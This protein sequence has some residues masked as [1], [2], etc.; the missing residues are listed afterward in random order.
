MANYEKLRKEI[1]DM[2][3]EY[4]REDKEV[5][6]YKELTALERKFNKLF[7][8]VSFQLLNDPNDKFYG[9]WLTN[10]NRVKCYV[11]QAPMSHQVTNTRINLLLNPLLLCDYDNETFKLFMKHE[12][13]HLISEHY[14]RVDELTLKYPR[15]LPLLSADLVANCILE[16]DL[17]NKLPDVFWTDR[18]LKRMF[19]IDINL[20][21]D[22]STVE[23]VCEKLAE[24][25]KTNEL[26][27]EFI[28]KGSG[29]DAES[30]LFKLN[31]ALEKLK[32]MSITGEGEGLEIVIPGSE[33]E[34][35]EGGSGEGE[36]SGDGNAKGGSSL[37]TM[38]N[39]LNQSM[40]K[41]KNADSLLISD[42]LKHITIDSIS[43]SRGKYPGSLAGLIKVLTAPPVITWES[44]LRR[45]IGSIA[46]GKKPTL[47][48]RNRRLP[49]RIDLKGELRDKEI[50]LVVAIDT[51][52]SMSDEVIGKCM[53]EIF[54]ITRLMKA[55]ITILEFDSKVEREYKANTKSDVKTEVLGRGGTSFTPVFEWINE[56]KKKESVLLVMSDGFGENKLGCKSN[57]HQ[58]TL[59]LMT[60]AREDLSLKGA[61][62]PMR[63]K[64]ISLTNK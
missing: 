13:I 50:D 41:G 28:V 15:I 49:E 25:M 1:I 52:G 37:K 53:T 27:N 24:E 12:V 9:T 40:I 38:A 44:E 36:G 48:R 58:G 16:S 54:D 59:W 31:D 61:N 32:D 2:R 63:S 33:G 39:A 6:T 47:F 19:D 34:D 17:S 3:N 30:F 18:S 60:E 22:T 29:A 26:F 8:I 62:L 5:I 21:K 46:A 7:E 4:N 11:I 56:N 64:V 35:G 20:D 55:E 23:S 10:A 45:F 51:S 57:K 14:K 42:M 43:Q